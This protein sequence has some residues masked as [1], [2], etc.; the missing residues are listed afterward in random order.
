[1]HLK[2]LAELYGESEELPQLSPRES[3]CLRWTAQGKAHTEIAIILGLS[4]HTVRDYLKVARA[5]LDS[6]SLAQAVAKAGSMG[7]I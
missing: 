2:S 1:M 7:L 6:V 5:K 4:E 3:E